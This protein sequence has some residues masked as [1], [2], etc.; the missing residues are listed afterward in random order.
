MNQSY[1]K[2]AEGIYLAIMRICNGLQWIELTRMKP[3]PSLFTFSLLIYRIDSANIYRFLLSTVSRH[4]NHCAELIIIVSLQDWWNKTITKTRPRSPILY[5]G[6][7]AQDCGDSIA[8]TLD[9]PQNMMAW[10]NWNIS[11][12]TGPLW[13]E[14][15]GHLWIPLIKANGAVPWCFHWSAPEQTVE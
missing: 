4:K 14:F 3:W 13:G 5:I 11:R 1:D 7:S 2:Y 9:L 15:A 8:N 12:I 10:T 6:G